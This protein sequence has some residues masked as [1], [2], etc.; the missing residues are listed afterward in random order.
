MEGNYLEIVLPDG[1]VDAVTLVTYLLSDDGS[2]QYVI[3]SRGETY[4]VDSDKIIY[5]S[6]LVN[7]GDSLVLEEITDDNEW[8]DVQKYMRRIA[9]T[10]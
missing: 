7:D 4:G 1:S 9:N 6:K 8:L 5:V 3:Y 2:R 10:Q